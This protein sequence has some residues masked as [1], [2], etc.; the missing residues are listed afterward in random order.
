MGSRTL[1]GELGEG[2]AKSPRVNWGF[3][4]DKEGQ[5]KDKRYVRKGMAPS[6]DHGDFSEVGVSCV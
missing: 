2:F 3:A 5:T 6:E 4:G 1:S